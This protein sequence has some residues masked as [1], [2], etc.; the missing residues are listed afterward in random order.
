M[1]EELENALAWY[2]SAPT[3][4]T[5]S[6]KQDLSAAAEWIWEVLQGDF[7]DDQTTA[8]VIT[9]TVISMIPLVDQICDVRDVVANCNKINQDSSNKVTWLALG[10][11]LIGLI[12]LL[13]S[14]FKGCAK[15]L[16]SY[17]RRGLLKGVVKSVDSNLW[18][19][20]TPFVE[21]SIAKLNV[22][23]ASPAVRKTLAL[24][25]IDNA[26]K[27]LAKAIRQLK[28]KVSTTA[29][30]KAF[31]QI[32]AVL[33]DLAGLMD[34]WG[35]AALKTK[36]GQMLLSV[37]RVRDQAKAGLD[38]ITKPLQDWLERLARR[39]DVEADMVYRGSPKTFN[40][41]PLVRP[42][43][44]AELAAFRKEKPEWVSKPT[45]K[46][47]FSPLDDPPKKENWPD[48][49]PTV[50]PGKRHPLKEAYL[51]FHDAKP[52][53]FPPGTVLYRVL[54]P[55]SGDNSI[56]WM[57]KEMFESL[58]SKA[59]WR[60]R[61][62]V[63][64]HWNSNGEYVTYTVPPGEPLRAWVGPA[65]TQEFKNEKKVVEFTL[66]GGGEQ[67]VLDPAHLDMSYIS[68]R[69]PTGWDYGDTTHK[70]DLT[71]VP[72]LISNWFK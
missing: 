51:T 67:V 65:A 9:G 40:L 37:K 45:K 68:K 24:H 58:K 43:N 28:G 23:L 19:A 44:E 26:Y 13:G 17:V 64:R 62:A 20:T 48:L 7:Y 42:T 36:A 5:Q 30:L 15:V 70:P 71:G 32:I 6:A 22:H 29:M 61:L 47:K 4:W 33:Q 52:A 14:L 60:E 2:G 49:N 57:T 50:E 69:K 1:W 8:Q 12:P 27:E 53:S 55:N 56:C 59:D 3:R 54:D 25:K 38:S 35:S 66:K 18:K 72:Q 16:F 11:T 34:K 10:L 31:D 46:L 63:W 21:A 41:H 39:L